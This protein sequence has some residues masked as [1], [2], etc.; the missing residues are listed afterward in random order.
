EGRADPQHHPDPVTSLVR[1]RPDPGRPGPGSGPP[2][3][4]RDGRAVFPSSP[5]APP[6]ARP[7]LATAAWAGG[8]RRLGLACHSAGPVGPRQPWAGTTWPPP[9]PIW[10]ATSNAGPATWPPGSWPLAPLAGGN[11]TPRQSSTWP[12]ARNSA[13]SP[14]RPG[15]S[16]TCSA[17]SGATLATPT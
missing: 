11:A 9:P 14:R 8:G 4:A 13:A 15:W 2:P 7:V 1:E 17:S 16:G 12:T 6:A 3:R 5:P 10:S